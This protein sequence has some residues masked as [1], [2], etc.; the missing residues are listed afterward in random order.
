MSDQSL[1]TIAMDLLLG[2]A[3]NAFGKLVAAPIGRTKL[4]L[5]TQV[6]YRAL[7]Y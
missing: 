5:Q 7:P 2:G 4:L 3:K 6:H 1:R